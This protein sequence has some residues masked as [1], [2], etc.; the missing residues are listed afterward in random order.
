MKLLIVT[1]AIDKNHPILGFFH[2]W[3]LEFAKYFDELHIICLQKGEYNLPSHVH[4]YSLGKEDGENRFKYLYR[5]YKYFGKIFFKVRVD[6]VFFHMGSVFTLVAIP[7]ALIRRIMNTKFYWWKAHGYIGIKERI[8]LFFVD[9]VYTA[10]LNSFPIET[11]KKNV[12]GH[13]IDTNLFKSEPR[14]IQKKV[15]YVG[16]ISSVKCLEVFAGVAEKLVPINYECNVVGSVGDEGYYEVIKKQF[17]EVGVIYIGSKPY[18]SLPD[19]YR[20]HGFFLNTSLTHSMD[21]TVL[22]AILCG[23]IPL[24]ANKAFEKMLS[25]YG[26]FFSEQDVISY[27][28]KILSLDKEEMKRISEALKKQVQEEHSLHTFPKRIFKE[29]N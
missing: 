2:G 7:F 17:D 28:D 15:L 18:E 23:C 6:Y 11:N 22:E 24:T 12:V 21:K 5:F 10:T 29:L 3:V 14:E 4:V 8:S 16:R 26:L 19:I 27:V 13:A 20:D 25:Q 9:K 1:Q